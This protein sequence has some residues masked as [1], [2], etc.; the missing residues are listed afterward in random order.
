ME[1]VFDAYKGPDIMKGLVTFPQAGTSLF[2]TFG[3]CAQIKTYSV[4]NNRLFPVRVLDV[5][6][7]LL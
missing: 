2:S 3:R 6:A 1:V 4:H 7:E 5:K